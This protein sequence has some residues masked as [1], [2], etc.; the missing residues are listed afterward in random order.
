MLKSKKILAMILAGV[1]TLSMSMTA[2]AT[3]ELPSDSTVTGDGENLNID[4]EKIYQVSLPT[5]TALNFK[6]DPLGL[7]GVGAGESKTLEELEEYAGKIKFVDYTPVVLNESSVPITLSVTLNITGS[8]DATDIAETADAAQTGTDPKLFIGVR[9]ASE[10][11]KDDTMTTEDFVGNMEL[12]LSKT[13]AI[14]KFVL[15]QATYKV[16]GDDHTYNFVVGSGFGTALLF[17]GVCNTVGDYSAF[18]PAPA[19]KST[20]TYADF[21]DT[22]ALLG[23]DETI[24]VA[25]VTVTEGVDEVDVDNAADKLLE[26]LN[27]EDT[28]AAKDFD[29]YFNGKNL[30]AKAKTAGA[31]GTSGPA[32]LGASG[33]TV[34]TISEGS[35][36][37]VTP[38][39]VAG[40]EAAAAATKT[41]GIS[42]V[43]SVADALEADIELADVEGAYGLKA[44]TGVTWVEAENAAVKA[45]FAS[46]TG[47]AKIST[48]TA[49]D[50]NYD[51]KTISSFYSGTN[52]ISTD[53]TQTSHYVTNVAGNKLSMR[54]GSVGE[55]AIK[56]TM[57]DGTIHNFTLTV[58]N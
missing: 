29:W 40:T 13:P 54:F 36:Q 31:P 37:A 42:A 46:S 2:L 41:V 28:A 27:A 17:D 57:N 12:A 38:G 35:A 30:V 56:V 45:G 1:M 53:T 23:E 51:G 18:R 19:T 6:I 34:G 15:D 26:A 52:S 50:F 48:L 49:F 21:T 11:L 32:A 4:D 8:L 20:Y 3:D 5:N 22:I 39:A 33:G 9:A 55:K 16:S 24:I 58:T 44:Q 10:A 7:L 14:P 43:F 25:G 47:T